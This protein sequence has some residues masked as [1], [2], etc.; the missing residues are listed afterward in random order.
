MENL[1]VHRRLFSVIFYGSLYLFLYVIVLALLL[2]TPADAIER[3]LRNKQIYNIWILTGGYVFTVLA[4]TFVFFTRLYINK[5]ELASIP[6]GWVPV[7]KGDVRSVVYKM[8][9]AGLSRS[10]AV[11]YGARPR[12]Q[13]EGEPQQDEAERTRTK[14]GMDH[15]GSTSEE[16]TLPLP[17]RQPAWSNIE[18][19]GWAS[20]NSPGLPNLQYN[21]VFSELPNLI[22]GKALTLAPPDPTSQSDPPL[23][24][25]EAV[26]LL[27][28]TANMG[29]RDYMMHLSELGVLEMDATTTQ[30]L[31]L[32]EYARFST[33]PISNA[34]FKELMHLFAEILRIMEPV[35]PDV[36]DGGEDEA[37]TP[38]ESIASDDAPR[39]RPATP[40][41]QRSQ[42]SQR[43][44][45]S[46]VTASPG[47]STRRG[48][49]ASS[50]SW[51]HFRTAPNS[52]RSRMTGATGA[53]GAVSRKSS[54]KSLAQ[55][56]RRYPVSS[57]P[58]TSSLRSRAS[59]SSG[60]VIRL[61]T[62]QDLSDLPYILS[63]RETGAS[64]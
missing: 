11:A 24:D 47:T 39:T 31:S 54:N 7:E 32:Y 37:M 50:N 62:R 30:F 2:V 36:L 45:V 60:S 52:F 20:P 28:R 17:N 14:L 59:G 44:E 15:P 5:T 43:S 40:R 9:A 41:S 48:Q 3:S 63:L 57:Q 27:Q 10:A 56:R 29:L 33:R 55:S 21:T 4:V 51:Y 12:L 6:K 46:H 49:R 38:T 34:R 1:M 13:V 22:E 61:A 53:T 18:H 23:L 25:P 42:R 16:M 35:N 8:I 19:L 26:A 64:C 58:S